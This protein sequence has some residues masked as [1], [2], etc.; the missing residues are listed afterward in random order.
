MTAESSQNLKIPMWTEPGSW[1]GLSSDLQRLPAGAEL[2]GATHLG[3][4]TDKETFT[5]VFFRSPLYGDD[6]KKFWAPVL[7]AAGCTLV[8]DD[9]DQN[10]TK[11]TWRC[12][13]EKGG[14]VTVLSALQ[15]E[16]YSIGFL[17]R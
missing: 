1:A 13:S 8:D 7:T 9:S 10:Q 2:C 4:P 16:L 5:S 14:T 3:K 15:Y 17:R 12:P 6:L 11:F